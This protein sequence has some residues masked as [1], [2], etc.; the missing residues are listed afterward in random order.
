VP[1]YFRYRTDLSAENRV[2]LTIYD[3]GRDDPCHCGSGKKFKKCHGPPMSELPKQN[4]M[5]AK[6]PAGMPGMLQYLGLVA[7]PAPKEP[8]APVQSGGPGIY[9]V[10]LT[11]SR[12]GQ[13]LMREGQV[14][15]FENMQ[16]DSH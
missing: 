12:P 5:S 8:Y 14:T 13:P 7:M 10:V 4:T 15:S 9:K 16:G 11:L 1:N 2:K 6:I 3:G